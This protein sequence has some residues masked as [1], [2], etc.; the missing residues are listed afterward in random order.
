MFTH[1]HPA[2]ALRRSLTGVAAA[3]ALALV[4]PAIA[5]ADPP[6]DGATVIRDV[7]QTL[8]FTNP[9]TGATSEL[10]I[11]YKVVTNEVNADGPPLLHV[12]QSYVGDFALSDGTTGHFTMHGSLEATPDGLVAPSTT[13]AHGTTADGSQYSLHFVALGVGT[14]PQITVKFEHCA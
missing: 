13:E 5:Q 6:S 14:P 3:A 11:T 9:C 7:T 2:N 4:V 1:S 8:P 10:T 12:T